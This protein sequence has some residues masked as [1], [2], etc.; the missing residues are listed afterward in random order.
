M[1]VK[2]RLT[3]QLNSLYHGTL[4]LKETKDKFL[5]LSN[6][7]LNADKKHVLKLGLNCNLHREIGPIKKKMEIELL[8]QRLI[9]MSKRAKL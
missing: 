7:I 5:N 3:C 9:E 8:Y 1:R 6:Y 2:Q 4:L